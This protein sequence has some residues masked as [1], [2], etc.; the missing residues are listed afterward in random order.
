MPHDLLILEVKYY[1]FHRSLLKCL[2][3]YL[4]GRQR[5]FISGVPESWVDCYFYYAQTIHQLV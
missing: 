3:S 1:G 4:S 2:G 5:V